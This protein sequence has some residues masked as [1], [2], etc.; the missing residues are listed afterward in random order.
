MKIKPVFMREENTRSSACFWR[1]A[2]MNEWWCSGEARFCRS[3]QSNE[4]R[5]L[6][7][8][9]LSR[10][11]P[12]MIAMSLDRNSDKLQNDSVA[13]FGEDRRGRTVS[14]AF[15]A[16]SNKRPFTWSMRYHPFPF[17]YS[18]WRGFTLVPAPARDSSELLYGRIR[19]AY[20]GVWEW[21]FSN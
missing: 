2:W 5:A 18:I 20:V 15:L 11:E 19:L 3:S 4:D 10:A 16:S 12:T 21:P 8:P 14:S 7:G 13:S 9:L 6:I 17:R 1:R